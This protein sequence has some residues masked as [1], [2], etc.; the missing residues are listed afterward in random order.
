MI[1]RLGVFFQARRAL[2]RIYI[3][4]ILSFH[5]RITATSRLILRT[6]DGSVKGDK[7]CGVLHCRRGIECHGPRHGGTISPLTAFSD[8]IPDIPLHRPSTM[9]EKLMHPSPSEPPPSYEDVSTNPQPSKFP[10]PRASLP[11]DLPLISTLRSKRVILAS[12]SARRKQL[13]AQVK[14]LNLYIRV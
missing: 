8:G 10:I 2:M 13:L 12:A 5:R 1:I 3:F 6:Q 4:V 14:P 7:G 11:L 9:S